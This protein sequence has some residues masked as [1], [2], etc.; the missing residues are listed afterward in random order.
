MKPLRLQLD[1]FGPFADQE[2]IDFTPTQTQNIFLM[3]GPIGAGKSIILDA[4]GF[5]LYGNPT[6]TQNNRTFEDLVSH[7]KD[8]KKETR[9]VFEFSVGEKKYQI[10]RK[11]NQTVESRGKMVKRSNDASLLDLQ[12]G[13]VLAEGSTRVSDYV[14]KNLFGL[15][16]DQ[17]FKVIVL[18][19]GR[20][21]EFLEAKAADR[22]KLLRKIFGTERYQRVYD[23]LN[24]RALDLSAKIKKLQNKIE[25]KCES[26]GVK[27]TEELQDKI[28]D[29]VERLAKN[30]EDLPLK[31][32]A[33]EKAKKDYEAAKITAKK[34]SELEAANQANISLT[35]QK[36]DIDH[37]R[38]A[39]VQAERAAKLTDKFQA[40]TQ[41]QKEQAN[42]ET[43][44][45][46][47]QT[48]VQATEAALKAAEEK[49]KNAESKKPELDAW[50]ENL[51]TLL[52]LEAPVKELQ[53]SKANLVQV[54]AALE[55]TESA[56]PAL[57][58]RRKL[59]QEKRKKLEEQRQKAGEAAAQ[60]D[61][62]VQK[63]QSSRKRLQQHKELTQAQTQLEAKTKQSKAEAEA[64]EKEVAAH[65]ET[66]AAHQAL[67]LARQK[68]LAAELAHS[69][70]D[71]HACP[72]CGSDDHP[73][74]A[75]HSD[76]APSP[77][78]LDQALAQIELAQAAVEST[79]EKHN[80]T[81][82]DMAKLKGKAEELAK[83]FEDDGE[84]SETGLEDALNAAQ[85]AHDIASQ[86]ANQLSTLEQTLGKAKTEAEQLENESK[87][88]LLKQTEQKTKSD[89]LRQR[90][91]E[92]QKQIPSE[93]QLENALQ[94]QVTTL[95][96][97]IDAVK[98]AIEA[99]KA[100]L[101][102]EEAGGSA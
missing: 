1:C 71:G 65:K 2:I 54:S 6:V 10:E 79:R 77:E 28:T 66:Q 86:A 29:Q 36:S 17:F 60:L 41:R 85:A 70:E 31:I 102:E 74:K 72:V 88:L 46:Q 101:T 96:N 14:V 25:G 84:V 47:R 56:I 90:I 11:P 98:K 23:I 92:L 32:A 58:T 51:E 99:A 15:D 57:E 53:K 82:Q 19:Q 34:L 42:A 93:L 100:Q 5:A 33:H 3:C 63:L 81:Q 35:A 20:F 26:A 8:P 9:I 76:E 89:E 44:L 16:R 4:M 43:Q 21:R 30:K 61:G 24:R 83:A 55:K 37:K 69:L 45:S 87:A 95:R 18:Q 75:L 80:Q 40:S 64:V 94:I 39:L 68:N 78:Q 22:Q 48:E 27:T 50:A 67:V 59:Q 38:T 73:Q 62:S 52:G 7:Y 49:A 13:T 97:Q 91:E 12:T